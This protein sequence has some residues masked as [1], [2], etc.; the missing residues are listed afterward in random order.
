MMG[1]RTTRARVLRMAPA[2]LAGGSLAAC[3]GVGL[4]GSPAR[5]APAAAVPL[6]HWNTRGTS[7]PGRGVMAAL[8]DYEARNPGFVRL[9]TVAVPANQ[10]MDKAK[11]ALAGGTPPHLI[12]GETQ[13]QAAE[14]FLLGSVTDLNQALRASREWARFK[15]DCIPGVLDGCTWKGALPFMPLGIAQELT[16]INKQV[17]LRAGVPLPADGYSWSD[18]LE[19]G[20]KT[21][22]PPE[23]VLFEFAYT[24]SD[25]VRWMHANGQAPLNAER[26][27]VLYDT[28]PVLETLQWLHDQ[29]TRGVARNSDGTFDKG[30]DGGTVT[31]SVNTNAAFH[32]GRG[33]AAARFPNVDPKG[34]GAGIHVTH[35]PFGPSNAK[36]QVL[37]FANARGL[38]V[39]KTADAK[40]DEAAAFVAEWAGRPDVQTTIAEASGQSPAGLTAGKEENLPPNI[41][42]NAMLKAI[43]AYSKG[44]YLTPNLPS[45]LRATAI[46]QENLQRVFKGELLPRNAL[47]DAQQKM[48][49]LVDEDLRRG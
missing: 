5:T 21:A 43:N 32:P 19:L 31:T 35:Y 47:L 1:Q 22:R 44:A 30:S 42:T 2:M 9:A 26:T 10:V 6:E 33:T 8:D 48:Q 28:P 49:P 27:K 37:T 41:K 38:I 17:L 3:A 11:A 40:K 34:D 36:K 46:L 18:F 4:P 39:M 20:R 23:L 15:A 25:L 14:L 24:Y 45:W 16:G 12:G 29:V 7:D 13:A